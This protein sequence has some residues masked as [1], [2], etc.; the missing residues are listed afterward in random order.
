MFKIEVVIVNC[1]RQDNLSPIL[2]VFRAQF[3]PCSTTLIECAPE[4]QGEAPVGSRLCDRRL[5]IHQNS[6]SYN[7]LSGGFMREK[8]FDYFHDDDTLQGRRMLEHILWTA[9]LVPQFGV[10][11]QDGRLF[12]ANTRRYSAQNVARADHA[13]PVDMIVPGYL[14]RT[15]QLHQMLLLKWM[16]RFTGAQDVEMLPS[17]GL[18]IYGQ[19]QS[20]LT[21]LSPDPEERMVGKRACQSR[22]LFF[23]PPAFRDSH[24]VAAKSL[25]IK[26]PEST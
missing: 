2:Q 18:R 25:R 10:L 8:E 3:V 21:P 13:I 14:V 19:L 15:R 7:R 24:T 4:P 12:S 5:R 6:G 23:S 9:E 26:L 1:T 11:V 16:L 20:Y 22:C 17:W